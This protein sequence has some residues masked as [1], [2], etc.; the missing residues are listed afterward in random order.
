MLT[1]NCLGKIEGKPYGGVGVR[2]R[3]NML[4]GHAALEKFLL[5]LRTSTIV[6]NIIY[7]MSVNC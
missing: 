3:V 2:P 6:F 4:T 7:K 5:L 1:K